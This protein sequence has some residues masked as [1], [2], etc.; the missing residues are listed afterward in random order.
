MLRYTRVNET[1]SKK[2]KQSIKQ[3]KR[4]VQTGKKTNRYKQKRRI[5]R[6]KVRKE[7]SPKYLELP[8]ALRTYWRTDTVHYMISF[9][10]YVPLELDVDVNKCMEVIEIRVLLL[11]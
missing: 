10:V 4:E 2:D 8:T 11:L 6:Q 9:A 5:G 1:A 7:G 3:R